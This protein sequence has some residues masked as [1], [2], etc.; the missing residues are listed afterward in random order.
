MRPEKETTLAANAHSTCIIR[1]ADLA[2]MNSLIVFLKKHW[3]IEF[4]IVD[5]VHVLM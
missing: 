4:T 5:A 1:A 2:N 3:W